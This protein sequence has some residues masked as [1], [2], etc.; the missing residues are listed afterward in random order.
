MLTREGEGDGIELV[1]DDVGTGVGLGV[2]GR[3]VGNGDGTGL[4]I[5]LEQYITRR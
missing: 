3:A 1:G 5:C 4:G 2:V